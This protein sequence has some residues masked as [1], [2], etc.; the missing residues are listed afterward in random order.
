MAARALAVVRDAF[1][2][3]SRAEAFEA[4]AYRC[5]VLPFPANR[6]TAIVSPA[7]T[8]PEVTLMGNDVMFTVG[9]ADLR[10]SEPTRFHHWLLPIPIETPPEGIAALI[11]PDA[12]FPSPVDVLH[13]MERGAPLA[14]V[15]GRG[16]YRIDPN[17]AI[18]ELDPDD[19]LAKALR[20]VAAQGG[21]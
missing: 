4:E 15:A 18:A 1:V 14:V 6:V 8:R 5:A 17:G 11:V 10:V 7:Q 13:A 9:R 19:P 16:M 21:R 12:P 20:D 2:E 3:L